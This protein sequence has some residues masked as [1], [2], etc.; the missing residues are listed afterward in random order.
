MSETKDIEGNG[1]AVP[2]RGDAMPVNQSGR[3]YSPPRVLSA[4]RLEAAAATCDPPTQPY[5]K[6]LPVSCSVLGS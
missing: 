2:I 5:G 4:E 3:P 1:K 6:D